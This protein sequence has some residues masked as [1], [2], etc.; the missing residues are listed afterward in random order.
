MGLRLHVLRS[1]RPSRCTLQL[2]KYVMEHPQSA[3][4]S[5]FE[6][7][8]CGRLVRTIK[9]VQ[10]CMQCVTEPKF[11]P[12]CKHTRTDPPACSRSACL[13]CRRAAH[14]RLSTHHAYCSCADALLANIWILSATQSV[15]QAFD[16][17]AR[18]FTL[19]YPCAL[20]LFC[21]QLYI[22]P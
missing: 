7:G 12:W 3:F 2:H 8:G 14:L 9:V 10:L 1:T 15:G 21:S 17:T 11:E 13:L 4:D 6:A 19:P 16:P 22:R 20:T 18:A 5:K